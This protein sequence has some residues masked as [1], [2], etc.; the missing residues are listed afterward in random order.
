MTRVDW[1]L[2]TWGCVEMVC[3]YGMWGCVNNLSRALRTLR[4]E[5]ARLREELD[6]G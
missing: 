6:H 4:E 2:L 5:N 1:L 3:V